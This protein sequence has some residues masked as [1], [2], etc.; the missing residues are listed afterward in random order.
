MPVLQLK[1]KVMISLV[2]V[3]DKALEVGGIPDHITLFPNEGFQLLT[4]I[5][6]VDGVIGHFT[7]RQTDS[8][9]LKEEPDIRFLLKQKDKETKK[10]IL[11]RWHSEMYSIS[12]VH[13]TTSNRAPE[14]QAL[15][16]SETNDLMIPLKIIKPEETTRRLKEEKD[17]SPSK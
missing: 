3:V 4:E 5:Q 9:E 2:N 8:L 16:K 12:Y 6:E 17:S 14:A 15:L 7:F 10:K 13:A 11:R 1:N